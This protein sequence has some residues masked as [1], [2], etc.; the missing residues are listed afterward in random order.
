MAL[1]SLKVLTDVSS[2][3]AEVKEKIIGMCNQ[4]IASYRFYE[5]GK[6]WASFILCPGGNLNIILSDKK[7]PAE[8]VEEAIKNGARVVQV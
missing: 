3:E 1:V 8:L 7:A 5:V 4:V 6:H 2:G